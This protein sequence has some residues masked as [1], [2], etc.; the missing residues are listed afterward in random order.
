MA[1]IRIENKSNERILYADILR[2]FTIYAVLIIHICGVRWYSTIG[3]SEWYVLNTFMTMFR[4]CIPVFFMLSGI[5]I[6]DPKYNLTFKKLY[7]KTLP[8]LIIALIFW[9]IVYRTLSPI[10][11]MLLQVKEV[12]TDDWKKIYLDI[13]F[14]TPWHHLW[15]MY[16]IISIYILSPL[17]RVFTANAEKKHYIYFLILY[18]IFGAVIPKIDAAYNL[19]ISFGINE[20]YSYTGY[21]IAGYFFSKYD[22]TSIQ[23]KLLYTAGICIMIW[24]L[25]WSTYTA[26]TEHTL[27]THYFENISPLTMIVAYA[28]FVFAKNF[29][30]SNTG[31]QKL[32]NN[33]YITLLANCSLGI[34]L[35]HD[36]FNVLLSL[37]NINTGT[38][39]AIISV[40]ILALFVYLYS[41]SVVLIIKK[42]P[43]LNKWII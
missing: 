42:I 40:P 36:L 41:L 27:S 21:F 13:L 16:A 35:V 2:T 11:S 29:I 43:V 12:T 31:I 18:L 30:N 15:F 34:Y 4:W 3:T 14:G 24:M 6:L 19:H 5:I 22:L 28:V 23:K 38:F 39:P 32:K 1:E 17:I 26:V 37:L 20:L 33:K 25:S 7:T 8:R 10:V 9:A